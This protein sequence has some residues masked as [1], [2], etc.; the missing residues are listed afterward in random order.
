MIRWNDISLKIKLIALFLI[1]AIVPLIIVGI[2]AY[3]DAQHGLEDEA[4]AKLS[5]IAELK[6]QNFETY[7]HNTEE[8]LRTI[9]HTRG[10]VDSFNKVVN[11]HK[12]MDIQADED[13]D[14]SSSSDAVT[15]PYDVL[16]EEINDQL[17]VYP[18]NY[19]YSDIYIVCKP[20][21]HV[22]FSYLENSDLG[23][24]L[25]HG[26]Y[27][28]TQ[29][30]KTWRN[31]VDTQAAYT[32]DLEEYEPNGGKAVMF[33]GAPIEDDGEMIGVV[34]VK[35]DAETV[36]EKISDVTGLGETGESY[37]VGEDFKIRTKLRN[38]PSAEILKYEVKT[39]GVEKELQEE[40]TQRGEGIC[41]N[42]IYEN[43]LG[44]EV[45]GHNHFI[46]GLNW[47]VI[48]EIDEHEAFA[49]ADKLRNEV[50]L[51][52]IIAAL[53]I[54]VAAFF[55]AL[56]IIKPIKKGVAFA[57]VIASGDL[58]QDL[59]IHQKD[60]V[61]Q[62][63]SALN[64]MKTDLSGVIGSIKVNANNTSATAEELS[65]SSE[66]VNASTE[67]VS[68]TIQ[69]I[70]KGSQTL[71][72]SAEDTKQSGEQLK[73]S[74]QSVAESAQQSAKN[75]ADVND[76]AKKG[77]EA[78][79]KAGDKMKSLSEAVKTSSEVVQ[80]LGT[81]GQQI[82]K[83][84]E[85][86]N[87]ISEQTN[88]LALNAAI[89][90]ARAGEAG[91][92]F[93]VVADEVRKLAEE[94]QRATKQIETIIEDITNG[95]T[96]AVESMKKGTKEVEE[97]STV[98]NEALTS[99][100]TIS[101]KVSEV[102]AQIEEMSAA[103][104]EQLANAEKVQKSISDVSA[105]AEESSASSE[106]VSASVEETTASMQ[107]VSESAQNLAKAADELRNKVARFKVDDKNASQGLLDVAKNDHKV[108]V[109]KLQG[110][111]KGTT[112]LDDKELKDHHECRLGKWY[113]EDGK[114]L[115]GGNAAF[116]KLE[117]P[118]ARIHSVGKE[119]AALYNA[120]KKDEAARKV[121]EA[122]G[123]SKEVLADIDELKRSIN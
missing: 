57:K 64:E 84:I 65:A 26:R 42:E 97:G 48:T 78:A 103:T 5:A 34:I 85:V 92:G 35:I 68:S 56:S 29:L 71:S 123:V 117:N 39:E 114:R 102:A 28:D 66:E 93:A 50:L 101:K 40:Q 44:E 82:V 75:A 90:A 95:T 87:G 36:N 17:K 6:T 49:A 21:G 77:S 99:L 37:I 41:D 79:K 76:A 3:N 106:E 60:E 23:T 104:E 10:V 19:G 46:E 96:Q 4:F 53:V 30:A 83:V 81:K 15:V 31:V 52:V 55:I 80:D 89:E 112:K 59:K 100:D 43:Y 113:D 109:Q 24:N 32:S 9:G 94:S 1:L 111:I 121:K 54:A 12:E 69:E 14:M 16:Y 72:K 107:Q 20:H 22:M 105:V 61:G 27:K 74:I 91:R 116:Q 108:W 33:I 88:L 86:I 25:V 98:V 47:A 120:G 11:Y 122:E 13:Y 58:T 45:L 38:N 8:N 115:Y 73:S 118:H 67:Q 110:M 119:A 2:I 62:L 70:A 18:E 7:L 63:A 51:A